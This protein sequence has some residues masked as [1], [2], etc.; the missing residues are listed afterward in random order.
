MELQR[1]FDISNTHWVPSNDLMCHA[2]MQV[3]RWLAHWTN[4]KRPFH[5]LSLVQLRG[6]S[7]PRPKWFRVYVANISDPNKLFGPRSML[8]ILQRDHSWI[9]LISVLG[10][11]RSKISARSSVP[12]DARRPTFSRDSNYL[13]SQG[14]L[15][16]HRIHEV[17][18]QLLAKTHWLCWLS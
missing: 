15:S 6:K 13:A 12:A 16:Q 7:I 4:Q 3:W 11:V 17:L 2:Y 8:D 18:A 1:D 10:T 5:T 14:C 9:F